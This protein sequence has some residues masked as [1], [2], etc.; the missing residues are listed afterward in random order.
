MDKGVFIAMT[1]GQQNMDAMA[2]RSNNLANAN[3]AGFNSDFA[4]ARSMGVYYGDGHMT[5]SYALTESPGTNLARGSLIETG[6][7]LDVAIE[8]DGWIAVQAEDG[9]E[10]YT[11]AGNLK[12]DPLGQLLSG[13]NLPILGNG[14]PIA[15][16]PADKISIGADGTIT[17]IPQGQQA[18]VLTTVDRI[19]LVKPDETQLY[20]GAD[21]LLRKKDGE[22]EA[23]DASLRL[24]SGFL[25]SSNIN[26]VDELVSIM[27]LSRQF[28]MNVKL[29]QTFQENSAASA[30]LLQLS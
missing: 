26:A 25:E 10:A 13:N 4:Q 5:R 27:E 30:R 15:I 21:G 28:E 3:T 2:I 18:T 1:T 12:V 8:G 24:Q 11:R 23:A 9:T 7:D 29:M 17:I 20:K 6:R 19:R 16:P 14:G 22:P